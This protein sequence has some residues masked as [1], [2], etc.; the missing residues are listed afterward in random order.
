MES[1]Q[2]GWFAPE[3]SE[4]ELARMDLSDAD[5]YMKKGKGKRAQIMQ[6]DVWTMSTGVIMPGLSY[7]AGC[8]CMSGLPSAPPATIVVDD[9]PVKRNHEI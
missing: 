4:N 5:G 6:P 2:I 3:C 1:R 9:R 7:Y 8:R